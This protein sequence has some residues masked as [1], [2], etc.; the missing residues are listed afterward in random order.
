M[1]RLYTVT[2]YCHSVRFTCLKSGVTGFR[3]IKG[4]NWYG[5]T[6]KNITNNWP[7]NNL[8]VRIN[9]STVGKGH[10]SGV[11]HLICHGNGGSVKSTTAIGPIIVGFNQSNINRS[12]TTVNNF[13]YQYF[14]FT[15]DLKTLIQWRLRRAVGMG[16]RW[17]ETIS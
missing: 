12:K 17:V 13:V 5:N 14:A 9:E 1:I 11:L 8:P 2:V 4:R 16:V 7:W 3:R 10:I 6:R 15:S